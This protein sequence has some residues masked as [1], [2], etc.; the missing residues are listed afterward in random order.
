MNRLRLSF[1]ESWLKNKNRKPLVIRGA[2]QVGKTWLVRELARNAKRELVEINFEDTPKKASFFESNDPFESLSMIESSL[3]RRLNPS[4]IILFLDEIQAAPEL[5]A[6]LRWFAEKHPELPVIAAGS[7]LEFVLAK[8]TFSMPVGRIEYMHLEPLSFEEFVFAR[9]GKTTCDF[10]KKTTLT[11]SIPAALHK[12]FLQLFREYT[13]VGGMPEAVNCWI[14]KSSF[15]E[16]NKAHHN[17]LSTYRDDFSKYQGKIESA[18]LEDVIENIPRMI[19]TK[20]IYQHVNRS[21]SANSIKSALE[22]LVK[23]RICTKVSYCSANGIPL[24]AEVKS[25]SFKMLFLDVGLCNAALGLRLE[26]LLECED[27]NF[28]NNGAISE[29]VVG[30]LL[31]ALS[32]AY[33]EPKTYYWRKENPSANAEI[34]YLIQHHDSVVPIEVKSGSTGTLRSL[35]YFMQ[36]KKNPI[37][38]RINSDPPSLTEVNVKDHKGT[39]IQYKLLSLPFYLVEQTHRFLESLSI[40]YSL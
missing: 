5:L 24:G 7:L 11:S 4:K 13:I 27:L 20:F 29:Q 12:Q 32:P 19:G 26:P 25:K 40:E 15:I 39:P 35:H 31:R 3:G 38:I 14:K 18:R 2:R 30:Q 10:F 21:V 36:K 17:L 9:L 6:K 16:V 8:H 1:L 28:V 37:A 34:D 22:L 33:I 23:A